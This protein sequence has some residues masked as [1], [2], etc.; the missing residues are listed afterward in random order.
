MI[1][2][3][4]GLCYDGRLCIEHSTCRELKIMERWYQGCWDCVMMGDC[5]SSIVRAESI[6]LWK[7][8][9]RDVGTEFSWHL[10]Y[11]WGKT[12]EK[13]QPGKL[14]RS[15]IEPGPAG[16]ETTM[17]P[18]DH[19]CDLE[20]WNFIYVHP[21]TTCKIKKYWNLRWLTKLFLK[22]RLSYVIRYNCVAFF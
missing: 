1:S 15:G 9:I 17:L 14:T 6:K 3:M 4:L 18:L 7:D 19:S 21:W 13:P 10:S 12:P 11:S 20:F 2:G 16:W 8:D 22:P 5:V